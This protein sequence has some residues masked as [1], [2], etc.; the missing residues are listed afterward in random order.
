V[1]LSEADVEQI[2]AAVET[3]ERSLSMLA[4]TRSLSR[5]AYRTDREA[6]EESRCCSRR[7]LL[8][9]RRSGERPVKIT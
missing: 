4:E 3:M 9:Y 5:V 6:R 8:R 1:T 2:V 7:T